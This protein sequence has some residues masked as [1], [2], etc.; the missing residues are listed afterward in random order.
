MPATAK[1][2]MRFFYSKRLHARALNVLDA[3]DEEADPTPYRDELADVIVE[4]T[5]AGMSA[6]FL[7]AL[8]AIEANRMLDRTARLGLATVVAMMTPMLRRSIALLDKRQLHKVSRFM[9][10]LMG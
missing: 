5:K 3:I 9:R 2:F 7:D 1:P 8:K 4:L 6:Y 10:Q